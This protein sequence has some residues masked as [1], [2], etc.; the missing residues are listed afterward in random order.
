[1]GNLSLP[2]L[3][4]D[5]AS[6]PSK[7]FLQF[8]GLLLLR[9]MSRCN[10]HC[11]F[12]MVED[13]IRTSDD[14]EYTTAL[15]RIQEQPAGTRIEFFGGEP[16][17]YPRFLDL[18]RF[19]RG[20]GYSCS[21]A[22]HGRTFSSSSFT[23]KVAALDPCQIYI[24]TSLYG[25]TAELHDYYTAAE[26]SYV[27]TVQGI[28]NIVEAGFRCQVN[29]VIMKRNA[30]RLSQMAA[31]VHSWG[32][33][34]IKFSNL[35]SVGSCEAEAVSLSTVRPY[36]AQAI[37]LAESLGL[38][39][40]VE[41]T[42]VCAASGR[43]DLMSTERNLGRWTRSFDDEGECG[44]CLVRRWCEGLD[45]EYAERF[46][47]GDLR[48]FERMPQQIIRRDVCEGAEP[49]FLKV[50]CVEVPDGPLD[51]DT[52]AALAETLQSVEERFGRLAIF[53]RRFLTPNHSEQGA[54]PL[55]R[56]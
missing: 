20:H 36:L 49:E 1:M 28:R 11:I 45:P 7:A 29:C 21:I 32:V 56:R 17:I 27:Q 55:H 3:T 44:R 41:K 39:V 43:L 35:I 37:E 6:A 51:D 19:A 30:E 4:D 22:T 34:R 47:Y 16:T 48:A 38:T 26:R 5:G 54:S 31:L 12:C 42:P 53:P 52:L 46:G 33:P 8:P 10:N 9:L 24:R 18:L 50:H 25:D 40:T 23:A 15:Q 14:V 2:I 13:E